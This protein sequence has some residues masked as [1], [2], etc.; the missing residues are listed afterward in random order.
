MRVDDHRTRHDGER[1]RHNLA[2]H[3][4][5]TKLD[6]NVVGI[7]RRYRRFARRMTVGAVILATAVVVSLFVLNGLVDDVDDAQKQASASAL[8]AQ[9]LAEQN[10]D[11]RKRLEEVASDAQR[12][13]AVTDYRQCRDVEELRKAIRALLADVFTG[14]QRDSFLASFPR[15]NC[16]ALP[17]VKRVGP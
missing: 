10:F 9:L 3:E 8:Q 16:K 1:R 15:R 12:R 2:L 17:S 6:D 11:A 7:D 5:L 13:G 4:L 14:A